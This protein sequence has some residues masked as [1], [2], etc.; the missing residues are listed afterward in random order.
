[1]S[2][3]RLFVAQLLHWGS[4]SGHNKI[5]PYQLLLSYKTSTVEHGFIYRFP[6]VLPC[7]ICNLIPVHLVRKKYGNVKNWGSSNEKGKI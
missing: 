2:L 3:A 6:T 7:K 5:I 4:V 1:M